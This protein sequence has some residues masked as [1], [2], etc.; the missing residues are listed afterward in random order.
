MYILLS[1]PRSGNHL[2]RF[3]IELLIEMPTFGCIGNQDIDKSIYETDFV[4]D[5]PFNINKNNYYDISKCFT[6]FHFMDNYENIIKTND[7]LI[8]IIRNPREVLLRHEYFKY[9]E[10][11]FNKYFNNVDYYLNFKGNKILFYYEDIITDKK[12]F[13]LKLI[14]FL[15]PWYNITETKVEYILNNIDDLY[16]YSA[17]PKNRHWGNVNSNFNVDYYYKKIKNENFKNKFNNYLKNK[18]ENK[19]YDFLKNKYNLNL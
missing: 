10:S 8:F 5:I 17:N 16:F 18:F 4:I 19:N 13:I 9:K 7:L 14:D 15:K 1:Y 12:E 3:F 2:V 11:S 6:K